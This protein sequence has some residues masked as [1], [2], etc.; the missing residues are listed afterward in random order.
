MKLDHTVSSIGALSLDVAQN[1]KR[2]G[3]ASVVNLRLSSEL[4][5]DIADQAAIV[6]EAGMNFVHIPFS[7]QSPDPRAADRFLEAVAKPVNQPA[8]IHCRSGNRAAA[9]WC[10][11]RVLVD[12]CDCDTAMEEA[13]QVGLVS[14][15][16]RSFV[17]AYLE[18]HNGVRSDE[19]N[20]RCRSLASR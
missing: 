1:L 13:A 8:F 15:T 5:V 12:G 6:I 7:A 2:V 19:C 9:L 17:L 16:L 14:S 10:I 20:R 18:P 4:G 11:R 3:F